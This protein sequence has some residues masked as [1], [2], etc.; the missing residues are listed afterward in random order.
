[1]VGALLTLVVL[2]YVITTGS[3]AVV[4]DQRLG[5]TRCNYDPANREVVMSVPLSVETR[6]EV[7]MEV[8]AEVYDRRN[9]NRMPYVSTEA[10]TFGGEGSQRE[11][12]L[13]R[14]IPMQA[15]EWR[16]G[17]NECGVSLRIIREP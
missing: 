17:F 5:P 11:R 16:S 1:M 3:Q 7:T 14:R 8:R 10:V 6:G 4:V 13:I 15:K 9:R 12:R 2:L